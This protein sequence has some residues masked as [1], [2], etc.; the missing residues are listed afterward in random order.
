MA[1]HR[2]S[3]LLS[4]CG[5]ETSRAKSIPRSSG[6]PQPGYIAG[7]VYIEFSTGLRYADRDQSPLNNVIGVTVELLVRYVSHGE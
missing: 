3:I 5:K 7:L 4:E 2:V 6:L 1:V